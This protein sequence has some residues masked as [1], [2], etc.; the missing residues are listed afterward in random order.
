M[1]LLDGLPAGYPQTAIP[2]CIELGTVGLHGTGKACRFQ[3]LRHRANS[4]SS[5]RCFSTPLM[6]SCLSALTRETVRTWTYTS[7]TMAGAHGQ[8][9]VHS[10]HRQARQILS[11]W[12]TDGP[13]TER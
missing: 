4:P 1:R 7:R 10:P 12:I 5:H 9:Q 11:M 6:A 8:A 3:Q 13:V 2:C